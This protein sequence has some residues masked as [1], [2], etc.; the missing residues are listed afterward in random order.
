[1]PSEV[2]F[3][4][5]FLLDH[6][7]GDCDFS[8][9][10]EDPEFEVQ[11]VVSQGVE[12]V[13]MTAEFG[14]QNYVPKSLWTIVDGVIVERTIKWALS[15]PL[16]DGLDVSDPYRFVEQWNKQYEGRLSVFGGDQVWNED[17]SVAFILPSERTK[18]GTL[19]V[20]Q[21]TYFHPDRPSH[22]R[23]PEYFVLGDFDAPQNI[24]RYLDE[25]FLGDLRQP[26]PTE[27]TVWLYRWPRI[28]QQWPRINT[29]MA[30][31]LEALDAVI[32]YVFADGRFEVYDS[33]HDESITSLE[34]FQEV[35]APYRES[36]IEFLRMCL[37]VSTAALE[38]RP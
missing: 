35:T 37:Y 29:D 15:L 18:S 25:C 6:D 1:M 17:Q 30:Q 20:P 12:Y 5:S 3:E 28:E 26:W 32:G 27:L 33:V 7:F 8:V 31:W 16:V 23:D 4:P 14:V 24:E 21:L 10:E 22:K 11:R 19:L 34:R 2:S 9:F 13:Y 36:D 38:L